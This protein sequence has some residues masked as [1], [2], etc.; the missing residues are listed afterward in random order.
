MGNFAENLN[1]GNRV[2]GPLLNTLNYT[3][4]SIDKIDYFSIP[5]EVL[6]YERCREPANGWMS[7]R[8][9]PFECSQW[10]AVRC[11]YTFYHFLSLQESWNM[12]M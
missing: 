5:R 11:K 2:R 10:T 4:T 3:A 1:L 7:V 8:L 6:K 9:P 12:M